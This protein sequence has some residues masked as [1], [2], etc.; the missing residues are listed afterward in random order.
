[1]LAAGISRRSRGTQ[2]TRRPVAESA[3]DAQRRLP[4]G[5]GASG[6]PRNGWPSSARRPSPPRASWPSA[7]SP[8]CAPCRS[9]ADRS[10]AGRRARRAGAPGGA[11]E[12][13]ASARPTGVNLRQS[14]RG[15]VGQP[16]SQFRKAPAPATAQTALVL[17]RLQLLEVSM[18]REPFPSAPPRR[19]ALLVCAVLV[20]ALCGLVS[21]SLGWGDDYRASSLDPAMG[22]A[23]RAP[24]PCRGR[25]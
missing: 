17:Q 19:P 10:A 13:N 3:V 21:A 8:G 11:I 9:T 22:E 23:A 16:V 25:A 7:S 15:G 6:G 20:S 4:P 14:W 12:L 1:M 5:L 2:A 24:Q 18:K